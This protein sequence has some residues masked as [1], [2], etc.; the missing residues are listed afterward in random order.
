MLKIINLKKLTAKTLIGILFAGTIIAQSGNKQAVA[1][2]CSNNGHGN[3]G[4]ITFTLTNGKKI[5]LTKFDP[6]NPGNGNKITRELQDSNPGITAN[7]IKSAISIIKSSNFDFERKPTSGIDSDCDNIVDLTEAGSNVNSPVDTDNDRIPNFVDT[8]SDN[9]GVLDRVEGIGDSDNDGIP[10]YMDAT[11][12]LPPV[13][14]GTG[15]SGTGSSTGSSGTGSTTSNAPSTITLTGTI[16]DFKAKNQS[17]GHPDFERTPGDKNPANQSFGYGEDKNITTNTLGADQKPVYAGTTYS[18]TTK[19]NFDQWYRNVSGVNQSKEYPIVLER[20][21]N[22]TY[23]YQNNDFFPINNELFGNYSNNKNFHFTYEIHTQFTYKGG[24]T[25]NF[26][27]DDDVWVYINGKKVIDL[28]GVHGSQAQNVNLDSLSLTAGQTYDLDFFFA[29]RHTTQSNFTIT[30]N[31]ALEPAPSPDGDEDNDGVTNILEG[32]NK[33]T[34]TDQDGK[35]DY[36]D[37]D[38]DKNGVLDESEVGSNPASPT[39]SDSDGIANF[40]DTD[41]DGNGRDDIDEIGSILNSPTN[42]ET[43]DLPDYQDLDDDNDGIVDRNEL[44]DNPQNPLDTDNDGT[45]DYHDGNSDGDT[46]P[47][48]VE[49]KDDVDRDG[50]PNFQDPDSDGDTLPDSVEGNV[51]SPLDSDSIPNYL[52]PDSDGDN[53]PD[54]DEKNADSNGDGQPD[55][56]VTDPETLDDVDGDGLKNYLDDDSDSDGLKDKDEYNPPSP[57][58][59]G[60]APEGEYGTA[61]E[62]E[63]GTAPEDEYGPYVPDPTD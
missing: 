49:G 23:K 21:A 27:G 20:Q 4:D 15:S 56:E 63:Y 8:D 59:N 52:D 18:T 32:S 53:I 7:E 9:D 14:S 10:N 22:G 50:T 57:G 5:L 41:N 48:S 19:E 26:S 24:E 40:K 6:S 43:K 17:G 38:S 28:G 60:T 51:D 29:E 34:D 39:D 12:N 35:P 46:L 44:G 2:Q 45:P 54:L 31:I 55:V 36:Q 33:E 13:T 16:R 25:F 37:T 47:D 30:T 61:P 42:T 58:Q 3:N 62:G 11:N 1:G